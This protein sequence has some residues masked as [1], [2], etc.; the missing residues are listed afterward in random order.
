MLE[1]KLLW[2]HAVEPL[3]W[4]YWCRNEGSVPKFVMGKCTQRLE[5]AQELFIETTEISKYK[6]QNTGLWL[7]Q[8]T[9]V[10]KTA[11]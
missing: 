11:Q 1:D 2:A 7:F 10:E 6:F 4:D 9:F 3:Y 5:L 8:E